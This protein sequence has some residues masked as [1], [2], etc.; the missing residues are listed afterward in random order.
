MQ[1]D[2]LPGDD[3]AEVAEQ[4]AREEDRRRRQ[5]REEER[6]E[7]RER[8][9]EQDAVQAQYPQEHAEE[10]CLNNALCNE[11]EHQA[12]RLAKRAKARREAVQLKSVILDRE[13]R[14][15]VNEEDMLGRR[16]PQDEFQGD[17]NMRTLRALLKMIDERGFE[18]SPHQVRMAH[19]AFNAI[20]V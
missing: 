12:E 6:E 8:L 9:P 10:C 3:P 17:V 4:L 20:Q 14:D 1:Y 5:A 11:F 18:R 16:Q 2:S 13:A 7:E 15:Q 19:T